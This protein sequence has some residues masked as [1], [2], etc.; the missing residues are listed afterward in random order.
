MTVGFDSEAELESVYANTP[1]DVIAGI[2]FHETLTEGRNTTRVIKF[3]VALAFE[4]ACYCLYYESG[5]TLAI[6][7]LHMFDK[8]RYK[9]GQ[10]SISKRNTV[11]TENEPDKSIRPETVPEYF[12]H[13]SHMF[14]RAPTEGP[15]DKH[16]SSGTIPARP[17]CSVHQPHEVAVRWRKGRHLCDDAALPPSPL[18]C[19]GL[20]R[21]SRVH[22]RHPDLRLF[23]R[24]LRQ[25]RQGHGGGEGEAHQGSSA[26]IRSC[27][28]DELGGL[29]YVKPIV[30]RGGERPGVHDAVHDI[31][32]KWSTLSAQQSFAGVCLALDL[33]FQPHCYSL[34]AEDPLL[35][36]NRCPGWRSHRILP[37]PDALH[38]RN[39]R[40]AKNVHPLMDLLLPLS[41]HR[42]GLQP[43][44]MDQD[45]D[46]GHRL[47]MEQ[48]EYESCRRLRTRHEGRPPGL[49]G[50]NYLLFL[51]TSYIDTVFPEKTL[52]GQPLLS[53]PNSPQTDVI[54]SFCPHELKPEFFEKDPLGPRPTIEFKHVTK[55]FK[56]GD[57]PSVEKLSLK[58]YR[59]QITVLLGHESSGKSTAVSLLLGKYRPTSG[60]AF[61]K[62][63]NVSIKSE[64]RIIP[65]FLG[66]CPDHD[67]FFDHLSVEE[68]MYFFCKMKDF[69]P[70][71]LKSQIDHILGILDL[72]LKRKSVAGSLSPGWQ[73]KL[74]VA[75]ALVGE[76]EASFLDD[77]LTNFSKAV[78][79]DCRGFIK[80]RKEM[81]PS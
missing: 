51:L 59:N 11:Y 33:F 31:R 73:R 40:P 54:E 74:S 48:P 55:V 49:R 67:V 35:L 24:P 64:S 36:Q 81:M 13:P 42:S 22:L 32:T 80:K 6:T 65:R 56:K 43:G 20:L 75:A 7:E 28:M 27:Q 16:S 39:D 66:F 79:E 57:K 76:S 37:Q 70:E 69:E 26:S 46:H 63:C 71:G 38:A 9:I 47:E 5:A 50:G 44:H 10:E 17:A 12:W 68:N 29:V 15:M 25:L 34:L 58:A 30:F 72:E 21:P 1:L 19:S 14:A 52:E 77:N 3:K 78:K 4:L 60:K 62:G 23:P 45:G 18:R 53:G 2:V 41:Q 61:I 8:T